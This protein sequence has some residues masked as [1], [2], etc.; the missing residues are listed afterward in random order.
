MTLQ[1][2]GGTFLSNMITRPEFAGYLA[3]R[4]FLGSRFVQSGVVAR[5]SAL[6]V[7][8]G[9]TRLR[10]PE[11]ALIHSFTSRTYP[12]NSSAFSKCQQSPERQ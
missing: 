3:E 10:V 2:L 8:A 9:G 5:N 12:R 4:I 7:R 11:F 1:N 6:D